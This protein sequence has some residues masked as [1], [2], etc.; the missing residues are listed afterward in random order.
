MEA[1]KEE[2]DSEA[3]ISKLQPTPQEDVENAIHED[4]VAETT[5]T[6]ATLAEKLHLDTDPNVSASRAQDPQSGSADEA[7]PEVSPVDSLSGGVRRSVRNMAD[8]VQEA[9]AQT[10]DNE[11]RPPRKYA[12][13]S[14]VDKSFEFSKP[15]ETIY[16]GNLFFDVTENDLMKEVSRFG[17]VEKLRI[18]R[19]P[20]G[21][22]KG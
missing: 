11:S 6:N 14:G 18:M 4:N 8:K 1:K 2:A 10:L 12:R 15:K 13:P 22:S 3:P 5:D 19:D 17:K 9:A 21:L 7:R 16:I 20:R